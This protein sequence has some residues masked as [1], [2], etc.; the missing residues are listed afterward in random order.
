MCSNKNKEFLP[1][2]EKAL[3]RLRYNKDT[4]V[5]TWIKAP[6]HYMKDGCVAGSKR[7]DGYVS[8]SISINGA[9]KSILTHRLV[10]YLYNKNL[11]HIIDH[12]DGNPNNNRIDNLRNCNQSK[13]VFN[14]KSRFNSKAPYTGVRII[15]TKKCIN[16]VSRI[17]KDGIQYHIGTYS[18]LGDAIKARKEMEIKLFGENSPTR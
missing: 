12:I 4:G 13:N 8:I 16:Y 1:Y 11:P 14:S 2:Y 18:N 7:K 10:W 15:K 17:N 9:I 6:K 5:F 3:E